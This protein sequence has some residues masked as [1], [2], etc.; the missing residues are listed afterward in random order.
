MSKPLIIGLTGGIAS[1]KSHASRFLENLGVYVIDTDLVARAVVAK[2]SPTLVQIAEVFGNDFLT[3][4]GELDR[5]KIRN[6]VFNDADTLKTYE[7][8]ILP[9]IRAKTLDDLKNAPSDAIYILL[10]V[11]L[12]FEKGLDQYCD[13]T[14]AIDSTPESQIKRAKARSA[15]SDAA[16]KGIMDKQLSRDERNQRADYVVAN[17]GSLADFDEALLDFHNEILNRSR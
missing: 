15:I 5:A 3:A 6:L 12:L 13:V 4:E 10:V 17:I 1:G 8:I 14:I 7:S 16:L 9:A 2:G 11:P